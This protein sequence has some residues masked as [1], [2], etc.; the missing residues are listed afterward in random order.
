MSRLPRLVLIRHGESL[1]NREMRFTGWG[2]PPL[3]GLGR[4]QAVEAGRRLAAAG[5]L[6]EAVF[7]S[8][9]VR[10]RQTLEL[11]LGRAGA[12]P[13]LAVYS[14]RLNERHC[15]RW[16]G[17]AKREASGPRLAAW[18]DEPAARPPR[19]APGDPRD[20]G[21]QP[22]Y[23]GVAPAL[24]PAGESYD[25]L[26]ARLVPLWR[27]LLARALERADCVWVVA[28]SAS[29]GALADLARG[30]RGLEPARRSLPLA[31]PLVLFLDRRPGEGPAPAA[32]AAP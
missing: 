13:R 7:C 15:G 20:P 14:W 10:A 4:A 23:R 5:A 30:G 25:D 8:V 6:P 26:G 27:G 11:A 22:R 2:D 24:L 32:E 16:E 12:R 17:R 21:R 9:L 18:R 1:W 19:L 3:T 28:H 29:L 31:E